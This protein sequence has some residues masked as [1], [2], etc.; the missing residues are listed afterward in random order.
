MGPANGAGTLVAT[1]YLGTGFLSCKL[2]NSELK[3]LQKT[4]R[5]TLQTRINKFV[6]AQP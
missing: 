6:A 3:R 5:L 1:R 2:L 4:A